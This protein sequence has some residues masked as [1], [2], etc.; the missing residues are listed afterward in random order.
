MSSAHSQR[1]DLAKYSVS[2]LRWMFLGFIAYGVGC[3]FFNIIHYYLLLGQHNFLL[4]VMKVVIQFIECSN[5]TS[6]KIKKK[7]GFRLIL[8]KKIFPCLDIHVYASTAILIPRDKG[9]LIKCHKSWL[10]KKPTW[11]PFR[12]EYVRI[13]IYSPWIYLQL[14]S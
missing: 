6:N 4:K 10:L 14:Y 2:L 12:G 11:T 3:F 13:R 8:Y 7:I 9:L 5:K 1:K